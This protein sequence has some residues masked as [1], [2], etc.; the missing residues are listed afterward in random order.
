MFIKQYL[1]EAQTLMYLKY[2]SSS[3]DLQ[4]T[5]PFHTNSPKPTRQKYCFASFVVGK[6]H[7]AVVQCVHNMTV[8]LNDEKRQKC[9]DPNLQIYVESIN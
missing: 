2:P 1:K 9:N 7:S 8:S 3:S 6:Y 5:I 4:D